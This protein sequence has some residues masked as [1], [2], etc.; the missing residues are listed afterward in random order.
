MDYI[1]KKSQAKFLGT[2]CM[3]LYNAQL[4]AVS[5]LDKT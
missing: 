5:V 3:V 4:V 1:N 2:C